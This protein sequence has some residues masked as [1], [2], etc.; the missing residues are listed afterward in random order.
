MVAASPIRQKS[1]TPAR[2]GPPRGGKSAI[3]SSTRELT[4]VAANTRAS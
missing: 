4:A 3:A 1:I 2:A